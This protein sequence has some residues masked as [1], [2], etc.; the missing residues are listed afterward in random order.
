M[1]SIFVSPLVIPKRLCLSI[2]N[3]GANQ[4][5]ENRSLKLFISNIL[6]FN[7]LVSLSLKCKLMNQGL[8]NIEVSCRLII[9]AAA[10]QIHTLPQNEISKAVET[11]QEIGV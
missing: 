3:T 9:P 10:S 7:P 4:F 1:H 2:K 8:K 11:N 6:H 5:R